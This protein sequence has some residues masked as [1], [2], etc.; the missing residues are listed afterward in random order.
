MRCLP[1]VCG[2]S[3]YGRPGSG[4]VLDLVYNPVGASLPPPQ[5]S[6]E[7]AYKV[8]QLA[9]HQWD[10]VSMGDVILG[11]DCMGDVSTGDV[12]TRML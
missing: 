5:A 3:R 1:G 4:L 11:D 9:S 8:P 10:D 7:T 2:G 12:S 6:L